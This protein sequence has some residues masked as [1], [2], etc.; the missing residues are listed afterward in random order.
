MNMD[1][2]LSCVYCYEGNMKGKHFMSGETAER[3]LAFISERLTPDKK[4]LN[5]DFYGGEP[6][7]SLNLLKTI[8]LKAGNLSRRRGVDFTFSLTTNGTL[9]KRKVVDELVPLGLKGARVT[10]D[11]PRENHD[12]YRPFRNGRGS[13]ETIIGN[14]RDVCERTKIAIGGNYDRDS[15]RRF[16]EL[17]D[18]LI[19]EGLTLDKIASVKFDPI[20]QP[21][22]RCLPEFRD[23][24]V[25]TD[26]PWL[27][28]ASLELRNEIMQRGFRTP[29]VSPTFCV[30]YNES[31][32]VVNYDGSLF[33]CPGFLGNEELACGNI[34]DGPA[35]CSTGLHIDSWKN[36][37]CMDCGYLP[38]CFGGC[39]YMKLLRDGDMSEV[40]CR[41]PFL[42]ATLEEFIGQEIR[43]VAVNGGD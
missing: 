5:I 20:A 17:L 4:L 37:E 6:L 19:E 43:H 35:D 16:P 21:E 34:F 26:E 39:R 27:W 41:K 15:W 2:N 9:F 29:P 38:L 10:L 42:D 25:S 30:I 31:Q 13:F 11:G 24:C 32:F 22:E 3:L 23:G 1:C 8:A 36:E 33:K 14:I 18:F 28:K 40:D 12:R 7:L